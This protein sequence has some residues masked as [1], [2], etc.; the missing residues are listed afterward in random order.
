MSVLVLVDAVE[1]KRR[2][3]GWWWWRRPST[4]LQRRYRWP[5]ARWRRWRRRGSPTPLRRIQ[6]VWIQALQCH[7]IFDSLQRNPCLQHDLEP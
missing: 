6:E 7:L 2:G 5:R 1:G 4:R 3:H